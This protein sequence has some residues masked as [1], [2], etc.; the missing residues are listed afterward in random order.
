MKRV[1]FA[2]V[3]GAV[4]GALDGLGAWFEPD[5]RS[6]LGMIVM[7]SSV[8]SLIVGLAIGIFAGFVKKP[9][10]IILFAIIASLAFAW[11]VASSPDPDTGKHYYA[12]IMTT[13]GIVGLLLGYATQ[14]YGGRID[15]ATAR[16]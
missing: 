3:L 14:K 16:S 9:V 12:Q 7:L 6:K 15:S 2:V 5:V 4:L 10:P 13:G 8:K 1:L 11:W